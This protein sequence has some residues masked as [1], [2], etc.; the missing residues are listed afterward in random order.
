MTWWKRRWLRAVF[1]VGGM[2]VAASA[3]GMALGVL[4][5]TWAGA[6]VGLVVGVS[7]TLGEKLQRERSE[8]A[9]G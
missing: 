8:R 1:W 5:G 7:V 3:S 6:W 2:G 9:K 4:H